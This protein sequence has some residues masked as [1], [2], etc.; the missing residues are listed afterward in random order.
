MQIVDDSAAAQIEEIL[1]QPPIACASSLPPTNMGESMFNRDS[2]AQLG[3]S[4]RSLLA[5][6]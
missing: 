5:L 2:L 1:A 6:A 3:P 4:L